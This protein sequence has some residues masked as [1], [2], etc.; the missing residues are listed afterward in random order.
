MLAT[1][2]DPATGIPRM[3]F[4]RVVDLVRGFGLVVVIITVCLASPR[5]GTDSARSLGIAVT[6]AL[7]AAGWIVWMLSGHTGARRGLN[8]GGLVVMGAA[9]GALA[10]LSPNSP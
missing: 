3:G 8:L 1:R 4:T 5:P 6:L 2:K 7:S 9:G 10:G